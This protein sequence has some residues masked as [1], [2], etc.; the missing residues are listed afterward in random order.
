MDNSRIIAGRMA[1]LGDETAF[2]VLARARQLE[3]QGREV[4]H[5]EIGEPGFPTPPE[6]VEAAKRAIDDGR[7]FYEPTAGI[8]PLRETIADVVGQKHATTVDPGNVVVVPGA[9]PVMFFAMMAMIE[10]G[11]EVIYP[12]PGFP[13]YESLINFLEA[14]PVPIPLRE[15]KNFRLDVAELRSLISPRTKLIILNSP[16]NPTGGVLTE[17]DMQAIAELALQH[18][19]YILSDEIY[20]DILYDAEFT[21]LYG[22]D[23]MA[24]RTVMLDGLS[25][26]FSMTGW[27]IGYGVL[28]PAL[29]PHVV[30]LMVNS[31][32]CTASFTQHAAIA[33]LTEASGFPAMMRDNLRA[34]RD[35]MIEGLNK[36]PGFR[37][38]PP[39]GA[40]YAFPNIEGTGKTS[41]EMQ[42]MLLEEAGVA[43]VAGTSFGEYG[44]GF[45]R[46]TYTNTTENI[47]AGLERMAACLK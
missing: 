20:K 10:P 36:L 38:K 26:S 7:T 43:T 24:E 13:I 5:F 27:R 35:I 2:E 6:V 42:T 23:G 4:I 32:S 15:E 31:N 41:R 12:N 39:Q 46:L 11:D 33:A 21:S 40:F 47:Q 18:D 22:Y 37:C 17:S 3:A 14:T 30:K 16:E 9:K 1:R 44:E 19:I 29:V 28:P 25:K 45:I 34:R 8:L